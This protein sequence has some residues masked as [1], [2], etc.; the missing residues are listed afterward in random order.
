[1]ASDLF[2]SIWCYIDYMFNVIIILLITYA[3]IQR[4][5]LVF[6]NN[7]VPNHRI[8][9][10]YFPI[11]FCLLYPALYYIGLIFFYPCVNVY[12]YTMITCQGPCYLFERLLGTLDL[13][14]N[15]AL[16]VTIC[17]LVNVTLLVRVLLQKHRMKQQNKWQKNRSLLIQLMSI[18]LVH[19]LIWIPIIICLLI[20]LF[21]PTPQQFFIDL[22]VNL[23]T[24]SIY[25]VIMICPLVSIFTV[26]DL[27]KQLTLAF[28]WTN[29]LHP[30]QEPIRR[31]KEIKKFE[32]TAEVNYNTLP[33]RKNMVCNS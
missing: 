6:H 9:L 23:F 16:P 11:A 10:H 8:L 20:N 22:S 26:A 25:I 29:H 13:L 18:V 27:R 12:D 32:Q 21:S 28:H 15:L 14:I 17:V 19:N 4:Y 2:C 1:M 24:Y 3:S 5:L 7:L 30:A 33:P 31:A